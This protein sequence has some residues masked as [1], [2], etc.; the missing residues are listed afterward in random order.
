MRTSSR[1]APLPLAVLAVLLGGCPQAGTQKAG[2]TPLIG[3]AKVKAHDDV[4]RLHQYCRYKITKAPAGAPLKVG[5]LICIYCPTG[6]SGCDN[7]S[8]IEENGG[9]PTYDVSAVDN[10][11]ACVACAKSDA[12]PPGWT[13]ELQ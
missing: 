5:D 9:S 7:Y 13:R 1:L 6:K 2:Y 12:T 3:T 11:G 8:Q 4:D 10:G